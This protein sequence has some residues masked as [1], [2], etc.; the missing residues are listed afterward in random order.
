M[1]SISAFNLNYYIDSHNCEIYVETGTGI[2][3]CLTYAIKH[4]FKNFYSIE[5]DEDLVKQAKL[6]ISQNNVEIINNYSTK[7][8]IDLLPNLSECKSIFFFLDAHFP[9]ADFH[10]ITYEESIRK[11]MNDAL[12]LEEEVDIIL[13]KRD[14]SNDVFIIDDW[15]LYQPELKYE[16]S[17][18]VNWEYKPLQEELGLITN[19]NSIIKKFEKT[20]NY[21]VNPRHQGYLI[22]TPKN[23]V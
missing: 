15:F 13:S 19:G 18:T 21:T 11:Y 16:A 6:K 17:N 12:P 3:E 20:H 10:K 14:I 4:P 7:A 5:L 2:A 23:N 8:L 1:G 22:L 9:G